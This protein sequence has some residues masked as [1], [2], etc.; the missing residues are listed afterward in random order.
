MVSAT[1]CSK[2]DAFVQ[3]YTNKLS[4]KSEESPNNECRLWTGTV[5][6]SKL[7]GVINF[8]HPFKHKWQQMKVHRFCYMLFTG[9]FDISQYLDCSHICHNNMCINPSHISLEPRH[10]NNNRNVCKD[11]KVCMSHGQYQDCRIDLTL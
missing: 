10:I 1:T 7:Y 2:M 4:E 9:N 5:S 8:K 11:R 6:H 3:K